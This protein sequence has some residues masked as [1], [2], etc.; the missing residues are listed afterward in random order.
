MMPDGMTTDP[1][2][3]GS[4]LQD[5]PSSDQEARSGDTDEGTGHRRPVLRTAR[6]LSYAVFGYVMIVEVVLAIGFV[7]LLVG[8]EPASWFVDLVYRSVDRAMAPFR[9][10]FPS[11]SLESSEEVDPILESSILFAMVVYGI[12]ALAAHDLAEW[13]GRPRHD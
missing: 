13:I 12:I 10:M 9:G 4:A 1:D 6:L 5:G 2:S 11:T 8:V 3:S 7:C